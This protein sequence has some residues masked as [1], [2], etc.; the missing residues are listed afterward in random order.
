MCPGSKGR[1]EQLLPL[2]PEFQLK[3]QTGVAYWWSY[4][5]LL[6]MERKNR[7]W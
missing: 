2:S 6:G 3:T 7:N 1:A 4:H 5:R